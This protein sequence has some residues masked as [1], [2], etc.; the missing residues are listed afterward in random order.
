M[1]TPS[2]SHQADGSQRADRAA[3]AAGV[4]V[5]TLGQLVSDASRDLSTIVRAE[6]ALAKAE[7]KRDVVA[8]VTGAALFVAAGVLAFLAVIL[9]LIAAAFGLVAAGL[10]PWL[11][12]L[13]VAGALLLI[14]LV[15]MLIGKSRLGRVGAPERTMRSTKQTLETLKSATSR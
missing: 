13:I 6:V 14:T 10:S 3:D 7:V 15:L 4:P 9:L 2:G 8:A 12:F 1:S 5:R 11:A